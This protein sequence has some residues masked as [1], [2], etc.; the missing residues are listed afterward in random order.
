MNSGRCYENADSR[1]RVNEI[2]KDATGKLTSLWVVFEQKC[3]SSSSSTLGEIRLNIPDDGGHAVLGP[4]ELRWSNADPLTPM[5]AL[6]AILWNPSDVGLDFDAAYLTGEDTSDFKI[7]GDECSGIILFQGEVCRVFLKYTPDSPGAKK[8]TLNIPEAGSDHVYKMDVQ[9]FAY[10]GTT[11]FSMVKTTS[12]GVKTTYQLDPSMATFSATGNQYGVRGIVSSTS[13]GR[14]EIA[15]TPPKS[16]VLVSGETYEG[17]R[18]TADA[19]T[20]AIYLSTSS[21]SSYSSYSVCSYPM[22]SFTMGDMEITG[23]ETPERLGFTFEFMCNSVK[24]EGA[25]DFRTL[26]STTGAEPQKLTVSKTGQGTGEV[27]SDPVGIACPPD[28]QQ[29]YPWGTVVAL[30]A[31]A[32]EDSTFTGWS[33]AG[34]SGTSTCRVDL[35]HAKSVSANFTGSE[36]LTLA[37][38]GNGSGTVSS[39]PEGVTCPGDC[40]NKYPAGTEVELSASPEEDSVFTGWSGGGCSGTGTC[41]VT[42]SAAKTVSAEFTS[43]HS[44]LS[45]SLA[46]EGQG[47]VTSDPDGIDCGTDCDHL[48]PSGTL[49][50]LTAEPDPQSAFEGWSGG[51]TGTGTCELTL[52]ASRAVT[53]EFS[54]VPR[55]T[56][57]L[58]KTATRIRAA[59]VVVPSDVGDEVQVKLLTSVG[60]K[61]FK[62]QTSGAAVVDAL[63]NYSKRFPR[64]DAGRCKVIA[65][66]SATPNQEKS[67]TIQC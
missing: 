57:Q 48:Y 50:T 35:D 55:M 60:K 47:T 40:S 27:T 1:F 49:V 23:N 36:M 39:S 32:D 16:D 12:P 25:F 2:K 10:A 59:G 56:L 54:E 5:K 3:S 43:I 33:G 66:F 63:G 20:P 61:P 44:E 7:H 4:R 9:G 53:A 19:T 38:S 45:V 21:E 42:M 46:G 22:G 30:T 29:T 28:C 41:T 14:F 15:V 6:P 67:R 62:S 8:A 17:A 65:T 51:C 31:T 52:E 34:C 11:R 26:D 37:P 18:G 13:A 24:Y 64:P 58:E